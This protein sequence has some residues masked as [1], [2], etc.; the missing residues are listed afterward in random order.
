MASPAPADVAEALARD[1]KVD[2]AYDSAASEP[3]EAE[4]AAPAAAV[5]EEAAPV[6]P[7]PA[8][9]AEDAVADDYFGFEGGSRGELLVNL[10]LHVPDGFSA[11]INSG[12]ERVADIRV[13]GPERMKCSCQFHDNCTAWLTCPGQFV[14]A[15][16]LL[17]KWAVLGRHRTPQQHKADVETVRALFAHP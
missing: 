4:E 6:A 2:D 10:G 8:V 15:D 16:L 3:E 5:A 1:S 9:E 14:K 13:I 12:K 17:I 11:H 7:E